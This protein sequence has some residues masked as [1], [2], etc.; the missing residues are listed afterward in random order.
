MHAA[1]ALCLKI[2][3]SHKIY[4]KKMSQGKIYQNKII[5]CINN[6]SNQDYF[7]RIL[8]TYSLKEMEAIYC[9]KLSETKKTIKKSEPK[10]R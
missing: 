6:N 4:K 9:S 10:G 7:H 8:R 3:I 1:S 5:S 2:K